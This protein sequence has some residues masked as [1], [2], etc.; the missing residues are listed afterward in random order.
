MNAIAFGDLQVLEDL[1]D[2]WWFELPARFGSELLGL[3]ETLPAS[4]VAGRPRLLMAGVLAHQLVAE[5]DG[6]GLR[7][8]M[9]LFEMH[10][11]RLSR[12]LSSFSHPSDV[13]AAGALA[14]H[15]ARFRG[16]HEVA[17]K[18]G[19]WIEDRLMQVDD[20]GM[21]PWSR[22]RLAGRPGLIALHRGVAAMLA[23]RPAVAMGHLQRAYEQA[24]PPPFQHFASASACANLALLAAAR[25]HHAMAEAWLERMRRCGP[26]EDWLERHLLLAATVARALIAIDRLDSAAAA[27]ALDQA[28][29]GEEP[30]ELWPFVA[31]AHVAYAVTFGEPIGGLLHL[32]AAC[33]AHGMGARPGL[34]ATPVLLRA[35]ADLLSA[36]GEANRVV[37]LAEADGTSQL[38]VP[39]ARVRLLSGDNGGALAV[40][41]RAMR[42]AT[43]TPRDALE[44][45]LI[46]SVVHL[47]SGEFDD[48][49]VGFARAVD[50]GRQGLLSSFALL[51]QDEVLDLCRRTGTDPRT[52]GLT[53]ATVGAGRV[54]VS[55]PIVVLTRRERA[56]LAGLAAGA[57]PVQIAADS[58]VSINTVRTQ[59]RKVYRKLDV[60]NRTS[61]LTRAEHLGLIP[62]EAPRNH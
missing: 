17:E 34:G 10:G 40:A 27:K 20:P 3:L 8:A 42:D 35:H 38:L 50:Y 61:A 43:V 41:R 25:G 30:D 14:M 37:A 59:I 55:V 57:S 44:L 45:L 48:A 33:F 32:D 21:L 4:V 56:V 6:R 29:N 5:H 24:G 60:T 26:V 1:A 15:A 12:H 53:P 36:M 7:A 31:A 52:L 28:G 22:D 16:Q 19:A 62:L 54:R 2:Q 51:P 47:R 46:V 23:G 13:V 58:G 18:I 9:R 49:R 11:A 39:A